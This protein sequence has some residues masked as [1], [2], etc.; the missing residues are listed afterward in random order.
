[1]PRELNGVR[2]NYLAVLVLPNFKEQRVLRGDDP[3]QSVIRT[4]LPLV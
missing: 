2:V 3:P 4:I 1:M